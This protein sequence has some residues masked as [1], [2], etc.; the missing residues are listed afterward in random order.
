MVS[1]MS[2]R[3][4]TREVG[5]RTGSDEKPLEGGEESGGSKHDA[6]GRHSSRGVTLMEKMVRDRGGVMYTL[7]AVSL[8][9][10]SARFWRGEKH[11]F[12]KFG[13]KNGGGAKVGLSYLTTGK[14]GGGGGGKP[15]F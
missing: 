6:I 2:N 12:P 5:S 15:G 10:A 4:E 3:S 13:K 11:G 14:K 9:I 1:E 8:V 7:K